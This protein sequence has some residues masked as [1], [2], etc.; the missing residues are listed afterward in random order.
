M[1]RLA[2]DSDSYATSGTQPLPVSPAFLKLEV[3]ARGQSKHEHE[4]ETTARTGPVTRE[5]GK[6]T[7]AAPAAR[8][9]ARGE[10]GGGLARQ[11][12]ARDVSRNLSAAL[13]HLQK[14]PIARPHSRWLAA[15]TIFHRTDQVL[16]QRR[17][18]MRPSTLAASRLGNDLS[19]QRQQRSETD[20]FDHQLDAGRALFRILP[21]PRGTA[22]TRSISDTTTKSIEKNRSTGKETE[23]LALGCYTSDDCYG[24]AT[25]VS[26]AWLS[27]GAANGWYRPELGQTE[28]QE[29]SQTRQKDVAR[30]RLY[31]FACLRPNL[32]V[33]S[34]FAVFHWG[35]DVA[36]TSRKSA[37]VKHQPSGSC[38]LFAQ[39]RE[40][41]VFPNVSR[42]RS[43]YFLRTV[44]SYNCW[45]GTERSL[46]CKQSKDAPAVAVAVLFLLRS[47]CKGG[48]HNDR[49]TDAGASG[50]KERPAILSRREEA[51]RI[52]AKFQP[53]TFSKRDRKKAPPEE[54]V[55][56]C[57]VAP[58]RSRG[59]GVPSRKRTIPTYH[60]MP[61]F[62][63]PLFLRCKKQAV[64]DHPKKGIKTGRRR[65]PSPQPKT[66]VPQSRA[67]E[68][69]P[70]RLIQLPR[71]NSGRPLDRANYG[72]F[73][74]SRTGRSPSLSIQS[75]SCS[76]FRCFF[77]TAIRGVS[78][79]V[80]TS[81]PPTIAWRASNAREMCV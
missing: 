52:D 48:D 3:T 7:Q 13:G 66:N 17:A 80:T 58:L 73:Y 79:G 61:L 35:F 74:R 6:R 57:D 32:V 64:F 9:T 56:G 10:H 36:H 39:L 34:Y 27:C 50:T 60:A 31:T 46:L 25:D 59:S 68:P 65:E 24:R 1:N 12:A 41:R 40:T 43:V 72:F 55:R 47:C 45:V 14:E 38:I 16:S 5:M 63:F 22:R 54:S 23:L 28:A 26:T 62:A 19:R 2:G 37:P 44:Y 71:L 75:V 77:T 18:N 70:G 81:K 67:L 33:S 15:T 51:P 78:R 53:S 42:G 29:R 30:K 20:V 21:L 69:L 76:P 8:R 4:E 11:S 49:R